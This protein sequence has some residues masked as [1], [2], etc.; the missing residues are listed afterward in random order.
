MVPACNIPQ[1]NSLK[2]QITFTLVDV[3]RKLET[4]DYV[5]CARLME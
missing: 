5:V 2:N 3:T 1:S 4:N